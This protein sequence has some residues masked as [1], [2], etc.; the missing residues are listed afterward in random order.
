[1]SAVMAMTTAV[2]SPAVA[3]VDG[4]VDREHTGVGVVLAMDA[5][6]II[7]TCTGTLVAPRVVLTAA[8]CVQDVSLTG[9]PVEQH[10]VSFERR[11]RITADGTLASAAIAGTPHPNPAFVELMGRGVRRAEKLARHD[12]GVLVLD[13]PASQTFPQV[14]PLSLPTLGALSSERVRPGS[15]FA[16]IGYGASLDPVGGD[17]VFDDTR[18]R[19][20]APLQER[21]RRIILLSGDPTDGRGGGGPCIGDSGGPLLWRG[22]V[23]GVTSFASE[24]CSGLFGGPRTD[25]R[26]ARQF[27]S[28]Y[29]SVPS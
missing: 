13:Q 28:R 25:T 20:T 8:H 24:D 11:V 12:L 22:V 5:L 19:T 23:A 7:D 26:S 21:R 29:L 2:A 6:G 16:S 4:E 3:I 1:M 18:R 17:L 9:L 14:T 15:L 27:L 10:V